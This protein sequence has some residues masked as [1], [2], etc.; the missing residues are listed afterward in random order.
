[1]PAQADVLTPTWLP[2]RKNAPLVT[3]RG[4]LRGRASTWNPATGPRQ[5]KDSSWRFCATPLATDAAPSRNWGSAHS[6]RTAPRGH[7]LPHWSPN[8]MRLLLVRRCVP[9][10][11][12]AIPPMLTGELDWRAPSTTV[13]WSGRMQPVA[14]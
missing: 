1:V 5:K 6:A 8:R 7:P 11:R 12:P 3:K 9:R 4:N 10:R 13:T 14:R 2:N